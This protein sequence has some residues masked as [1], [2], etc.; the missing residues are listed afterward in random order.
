MLKY[1]SEKVK[2]FKSHFLQI[3]SNNLEKEEDEE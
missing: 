2:E 3:T 1:I